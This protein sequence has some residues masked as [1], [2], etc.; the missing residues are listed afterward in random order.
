MLKSMERIVVGVDGSKSSRNALRWAAREAQQTGAVLQVVMTWANPYPDMWIPSNPPGT[1]PLAIT[2]RSLES[3]VGAELSA[4]PTVNI[5]PLVIEGQA[6][7]VLVKAAEGADLLVVG[8]RGRGGFAGVLLG[9]VS[10]HCVSH[11]PCPVVVVRGGLK[12]IGSPGR[13]S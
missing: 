9:S 5:D 13:S 12:S 6:A 2:R 1:D 8:S 4:Y 7:E 3:V 11:A 10:L